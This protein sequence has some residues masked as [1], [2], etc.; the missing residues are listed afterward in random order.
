MKAC[1]P[2]SRTCI[3]GIP[4]FST[5]SSR[6]GG[7]HTKHGEDNQIVRVKKRVAEAAL[8][9]AVRPIML[10]LPANPKGLPL[11]VFDS[12]L[13]KDRWVG[14]DAL[15]SQ[16]AGRECLAGDPGS[17]LAL[18]HADFRPGMPPRPSLVAVTK[19]GGGPIAR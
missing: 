11:E 10:K 13:M 7:R 18:E 8:I 19:R 5:S 6:L 12:L 3:S 16:P 1:R 9:A 17:V 15:W 2:P 4:G 14:S